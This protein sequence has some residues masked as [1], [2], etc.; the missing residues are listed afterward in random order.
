M[1]LV[2]ETSVCAGECVIPLAALSPLTL[3]QQ[4][5]RQWESS[6]FI[7]F[8]GDGRY[9]MHNVHQ[10]RM[11]ELLVLV[12]LGV[13]ETSVVCARVARNVMQGTK[14]ITWLIYTLQGKAVSNLYSVRKT[15]SGT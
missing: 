8:S 14:L 13:H 7:L 4:G 10:A 1:V 11:M 12:G 15:L 2:A 9:M 3:D 6:K 5:Y